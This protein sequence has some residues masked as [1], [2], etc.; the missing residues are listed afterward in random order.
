MKSPILA[1]LSVAVLNL[2]LASRSGLPGEPTA[3]PS[4][5]KVAVLDVNE[6]L[7]H[8][9]ALKAQLVELRADTAR[10]DEVFKRQR[11]ELAELGRK[12]EGL[13]PGTAEHSAL[14][15]QIAQ[16]QAALTAEGELQ[17]KEFA[18]REAQLYQR[19]YDQV[20]AVVDEYA[21]EHGL[22]VVLRADG[23]APKSGAPGDVLRNLSRSVVWTAKDLDITP[24]IIER[25]AARASASPAPAAKAAK[26]EAKEPKK[27]SP[28]KDGK[29]PGPAKPKEEKPGK[30]P[31][32]LRVALRGE[33][34][35]GPAASGLFGEARTSLAAAIQRLDRAAESPVA[36]VLVQVDDLDL[37]PGKVHEFREAIR[38]L[39]KSGKPVIAELA[40]AQTNQYL[41]AAACDEIVM[42]PSGT[43]LIPGVRAEMTFYKGLLD[44]LGLEFEVLQ[45]GKY[46][47]AAETFTRTSMSP[48]LRQSVEAVVDDSYQAL[49]ATIANDRKLEPAEVKRLI[50]EGMFTAEAARRGRLVDHVC[51]FDEFQETLRKR[52]GAS[53]LIVTT[54]TRKPPETDLSGI[55]G[56]M[57]LMEMA[58]GTRTPEKTSPDRKI[59][60][61]YAVGMIVDGESSTSLFGESVLGAATLA[62]ALRTA[63]ADSRVV[64]IV[65]RVDS[66]GGS[67]VASDLVWR[68]IRRIRKPVVA[69]LGDVAA[70][71]GY[72]IAMAA[73][74]VYAEP[75]T[76]TGSIGVVG[77]KLVTTGLYGKLGLA[78]EVISR[79]RNSGT[80][81]S[82]Q[83]FTKEERALW[84]ALLEETYRQFVDK[85]A[86]ARK[87]PRDRLE[88]LA[89]GRVFTG[90]MAAANGLV[91]GLGTL[92][93]AIA[94]AKKAAGLKADEKVELWIL[95]KPRS[96]FEHLLSDP[97][98][99]AGRLA[100]LVPD[101]LETL[102]YAEHLRLL[103]AGRVWALMPFGLR[104]R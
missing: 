22:S 55:S 81:S 23:G 39:R 76:V 61:I 80:L 97:S 26:P 82:T 52:L 96:I 12:L 43:L 15:E 72:Y 51:Y 90:R 78:T 31:T 34:P 50:D 29:K 92:A 4:G 68:E 7:R 10:A 56:M 17:Q 2:V 63:A 6:V 36:A 54:Q 25:L 70:S 88:A 85:A 33:Y 16:R 1:V 75:G 57:K 20:V 11:D 18:R 46:K 71:G 38:R 37:G 101:G 77:G 103:A 5:A 9:P 99:T 62:D 48:E 74:K 91:D 95:P 84:T 21:R 3:P 14:K 86:L 13:T 102:A 49:V 45:M 41:V 30:K 67:A 19:Y 100:R 65:L 64:A 94:E 69:S 58:F 83:R 89:Q 93:D 8:H 104:V 24:Q 87:M 47:G 59:A 66:P 44:K 53:Q 35:E 32:V 28:S 60:V 79:G 98:A 42:A 40:T 27:P 73:Q